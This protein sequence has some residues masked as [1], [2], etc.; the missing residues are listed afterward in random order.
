MRHH[1]VKLRTH[2]ASPKT[3]YVN[4]DKIKMLEVADDRNISTRVFFEGI[5]RMDYLHVKGTPI[6]VLDLIR[7]AEE[8]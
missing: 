3:M 6:Q 7:R 1:Y 2:D 5:D 8:E 4:T